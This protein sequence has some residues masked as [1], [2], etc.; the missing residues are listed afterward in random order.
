MG[1]RPKKRY[2]AVRG[3]KEKVAEALR[4]A[5]GELGTAECRLRVFPLKEFPGM[6]A[7]LVS[8]ECESKAVFALAK[9]GF[10]V[11]GNSGTVKGLKRRL[12][13]L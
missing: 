10:S 4:K 9:A 8:L 11:L 2:L 3:E 1:V 13:K 5:L 6:T 7:V 12:Q